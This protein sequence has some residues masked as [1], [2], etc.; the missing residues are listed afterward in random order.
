[1]GLSWFP[2]DQQ[3]RFTVMIT[4]IGQR[5]FVGTCA[6]QIAL[7]QLEIDPTLNLNLRRDWLNFYGRRSCCQ[8]EPGGGDGGAQKHRYGDV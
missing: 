8:Y 2:V 5:Q 7:P 1:M 6:N 3:L 4:C